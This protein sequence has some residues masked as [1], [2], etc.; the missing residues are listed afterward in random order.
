[1]AWKQLYHLVYV[2]KVG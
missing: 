1:M 2:V